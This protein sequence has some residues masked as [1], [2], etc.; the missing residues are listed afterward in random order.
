MA[1]VE[2]LNL[3]KQGVESWNQWREQNTNVKLDLSESDL[4]QANLQKA[5]LSHANLNKVKL[6][7]SNL[8][9]ANLR[10]ASLKKSKF[11]ETNLQSANL[12]VDHN[13]SCRQRSDWTV[14]G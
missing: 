6:Q 5:I 13:L 4:R 10:E 7:F 2:Q 8:T 1:N 11:Q 3:I 9:G 12:L 14:G